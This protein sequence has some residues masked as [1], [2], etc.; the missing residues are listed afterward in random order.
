MASPYLLHLQ[1]F[2]I[3]FSPKAGWHPMQVTNEMLYNMQYKA[4][5]VPGGEMFIAG[6][7]MIFHFYISCHSALLN[8]LW[9]FLI[10]V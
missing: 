7:M 6:F 3:C 10:N 5:G 1:P 8:C 2:I 9:G 4:V